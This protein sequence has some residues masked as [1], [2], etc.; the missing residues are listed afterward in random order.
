MSEGKFSQSRPHREEERQIEESFRQL[1]EE[2]SRRR[3]KTYNVE[4]EIGPSV[5]EIAAE[6]IPLSEVDGLPT[7]KRVAPEPTTLTDPQ[8]RPV[9]NPAAATQPSRPA[10]RPAPQQAR[11]VRKPQYDLLPE[12]VDSY[13][14]GSRSLP[15]EPLPEEE[16]DF[17]DKLLQFGDFFRNHQTPVILGLCVAAVLLIVLF[18]SIFFT[19]GKSD[20]YGDA[21]LPNVLIADV[22]V[23]GMTKSEAISALKAATDNT[24][25]RQDMVVDLSGTELRL[26]PKDTKAAL[27][28]KAAVEAAYAYG[29]TGSQA[30]RDQIY[31]DALT[32]E[33]V[34]AVLPY[35]EL[36]LQYIKGE[37]SAYAEGTGSTLT[38]TTYGLEGSDPEL[39]ADKFNPNAPTQTL[40]IIM[41][42]PG[43][44]FDA[45]DVYEKVLDAYSLHCF[46]VE[47]ENVQ[48][49][50][51]P[52]P[53]DLEAIYKEFYIEPVNASV[54]LQNFE[55]VPGSY[56]YGF[57]LEAAE[58]LVANAQYGEV[59]RIPMEYIEP[60]IL[61]NTAF[62]V[63]TLGEYQTRGTGN[64]DRNK[65][66][67]LA[68]EAIHNTVLNPG[69]N[70]SFSGLLGKV[71][72]YR[73]APEDT[74]MEDIDKGGVSQVA[75]T[76]Y[77]AALASDLNVTSRT[78]HSYMPSFTEYGLDATADLKI[79]NT[80][81]YPIRIEAEFTGG[82]VKVKIQ[83][84]EE[85]SYYVMLESSISNSTAPK[86]VYEDFPYDNE[87]GYEDGDVIQD[88]SNGYLVKSYKVRYDRRT[89][90]EQARDFIANSQYQAVDKIVAHVEA[91]P[92]TEPPTEAPTEAPTTAPTAPPTEPPATTQPTEAPTLPPETTAPSE[93][94]AAEPPV[95]SQPD[96][97]S[98]I[99]VG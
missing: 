34:I 52:E 26:S 75:S 47:V 16:P 20:P 9:R 25:T 66:L 18:V 70:L 27:D 73:M 95:E 21:I 85:R 98:D 89:G 81:G 45:N 30:Q 54:N 36:D 14:E 5:Q 17:I 6:E 56:G 55:T 59:L 4:Q 43:I 69:E 82:Y 77:Y 13:F 39:S 49:V 64:E 2:N 61:D 67:A 96:A 90:K 37:L 19:G 87:E 10:Q 92:E 22:N 63:D 84:T 68:C 76:L 1:T 91:P 50:S 83:G 38:Q 65:N 97:A 23:G 62:Y 58:K 93:P 71:K 3:K 31:Q 24:Y 15:E 41:G 74:G 72:G 86:T 7:Q 51:E 35:L 8:Q 78:P 11:P 33:H 46:L 80:T 79:Q 40:V 88:G 32:E 99:V 44:G 53:I 29:R 12:D 60:E 57:D 28:V 48:S 42:T 94:P